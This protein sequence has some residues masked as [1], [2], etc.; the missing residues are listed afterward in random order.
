MR[1]LLCALM[2]LPGC[3]AWACAS[4]APQPDN[5]SNATERVTVI[6]GHNDLLVHF[7]IDDSLGSVRTYPLDRSTRG[8]TDIRRWRAGGVS[9]SFTTISGHFAEGDAGL[10]RMLALLAEIVG[11]YPDDLMLA[12]S[13]ADVGKARAQGRIAL[14]P[15]LEDGGQLAGSAERLKA[16]YRLG[17]RS[18]GLTWDRSSDLADAALGVVRWNGVS[19]TGRAMIREMNR[20]GVIIDVSHASDA[21]ARQA[22]ALS[23]APV[24]F[25]HSSARAVTD[26]PR[27]V[28]D[29]LLRRVGE[30]GGIVMVSFVPYFTTT[31]YSRWYEQGEAVWDSLLVIH[32]GDTTKASTAMTQWERD[33]RSPPAGIEDVIRHIEHVRSVAGV[34]HVGLGSDFDGMFS[35]VT[36]LEDVA[37]FPR[38]LDALARRGWS[39]QDLRKL[40]GDNILRVWRAVE[41]VA[42]KS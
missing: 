5:G 12:A 16:L 10:R 6:D 3:A 26:V 35:N 1:L 18:V 15:H 7:L 33:N 36:G 19:P 25:S 21:A 29:H 32:E 27:N 20:L 2:V 28:P 8:Q 41:A 23:E 30:T 34:D 40:A 22:M 9:A 13:P 42:A 14:I 31:E 39:E 17:L 37:A 38:L 4:E 24:I 11:R